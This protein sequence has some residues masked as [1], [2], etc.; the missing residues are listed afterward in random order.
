MTE[1]AQRL[2]QTIRQMEV[3]LDDTRSQ[4][5]YDPADS[6]LKLTYP[7][8]E[9]IENLKQKHRTIS[10]LHRERYEQVK[11]ACCLLCPS[12]RQNLT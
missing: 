7:L 11:S 10:K 6:N 2:I 8:L 4:N 5:D 12:V 1:E 3:S 9:C